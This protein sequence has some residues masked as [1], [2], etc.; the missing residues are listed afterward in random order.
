M[1]LIPFG[2]IMPPDLILLL[3]HPQYLFIA[4]SFLLILLALWLL[5]FSGNSNSAADSISA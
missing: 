3:R 2:P 1:K 4:A 5:F